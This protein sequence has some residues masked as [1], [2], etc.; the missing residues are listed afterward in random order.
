MLGSVYMNNKRFD[1]TLKTD[2]ELKKVI[3]IITYLTS[4]NYEIKTNYSFA[5][6]KINMVFEWISNKEGKTFY[7]F[8]VQ[9]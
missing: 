3:T 1:E 5:L 4:Y 7:C 9:W 6:K 2:Y 8:C